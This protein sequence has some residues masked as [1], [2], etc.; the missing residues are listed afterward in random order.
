MIRSFSKLLDVDLGYEPSNVLA[1]EVEPLDQTSAVRTRFYPALA[2][3]LLGGAD[4]SAVGA[5]DQATL[6]GGALNFLAKADTGIDVN[7]PKRTVLP[8]YFEAMGVRPL[9]GRLLEDADVSAGEA[10]VISA[11][12]NVKFFNGAAVGHAVRTTA[13]GTPRE[14]RIVGV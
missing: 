14:F 8:G 3:A 5:I 13:F 12:G 4:V 2:K 10:A 9:M 1:F 6:M 11:S 7:G